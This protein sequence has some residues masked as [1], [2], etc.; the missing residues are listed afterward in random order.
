MCA[1]LRQMQVPVEEHPDGMTIQP[2]TPR[3]QQLASHDD[4]R[5]AMSLAVMGVRVPGIVIE[6][7]GCVSKTCPAFFDVLREIGIT[8]DLRA[9]P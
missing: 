4:H 2:A 5:V 1:A 6:D 7:P 8:V 9:G 3:G